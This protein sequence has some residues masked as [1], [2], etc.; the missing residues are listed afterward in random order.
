MACKRTEG[1]KQRGSSQTMVRD[2]LVE[3]PG[4]FW[5][6]SDDLCYQNDSECC[7]IPLLYVS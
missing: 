7:K 1:Q 3:N 5:L 4:L 2:C 6:D